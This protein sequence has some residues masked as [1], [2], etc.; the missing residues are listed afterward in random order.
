MR[1]T[2]TQARVVCRIAIVYSV[3]EAPAS[4]RS[5]SS[6]HSGHCD[7]DLTLSAG[8]PTI[9][10][11]ERRTLTARVNPGGDGGRCRVTLEVKY[12]PQQGYPNAGRIVGGG[13]TT[14]SY[15][16]GPGAT[17]KSRSFTAE[18]ASDYGAH[19]EWWGSPENWTAEFQV[20]ATARR[21]DVPEFSPGAIFTWTSSFLA[22]STGSAGVTNSL[23]VVPSG[24]NSHALMMGVP[25]HAAGM[26]TSNCHHNVE[27]APLLRAAFYD[28]LLPSSSFW[29]GREIFEGEWEGVSDECVARV[30]DLPQMRLARNQG[31]FQGKV[32]IGKQPGDTIRRATKHTDATSGGG[33]VRNLQSGMA[34]FDLHGREFNCQRHLAKALAIEGPQYNSCDLTATQPMYVVTNPTADPVPS[35]DTAANGTLYASYP[36]RW[37]TTVTDASWRPDGRFDQILFAIDFHRGNAHIGRENINVRKS[38]GELLKEN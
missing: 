37:T 17:S 16:N 24:G 38:C 13:T 19:A 20:T 8:S 36:V 35:S 6:P 26:E 25:A 28:E 18:L 10:P 30:R 11:G 32:T 33:N 3:L 9:A 34:S 2:S 29:Q 31:C 4:A 7:F 27:G 5:I 15:A 21:T 14:F 12:V 1:L 22:S 23:T